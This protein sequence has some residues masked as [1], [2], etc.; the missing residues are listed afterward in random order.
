MKGE[1]F[2]QL[3]SMIEAPGTDRAHF[4]SLIGC[5]RSVVAVAPKAPAHGNRSVEAVRAGGAKIRRA[6]GAAITPQI[7]NLV[8]GQAKFQ[9]ERQLES[10][11]DRT[12]IGDGLHG[13]LVAD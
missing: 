10:G 1:A 13:S 6:Q 2:R 9:I 3:R 4:G 11:S 8:L 12:V 7:V 5:G